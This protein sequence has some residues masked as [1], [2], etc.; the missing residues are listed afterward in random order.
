VAE[1]KFLLMINL[2]GNGCV[3]STSFYC[4]AHIHPKA[5][6]CFK[7]KR[8]IRKRMNDGAIQIIWTKR[9]V[10]QEQQQQQE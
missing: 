2:Y 1:K 9:G 4:F 10:K 5:K 8:I 7:R 6:E 3:R